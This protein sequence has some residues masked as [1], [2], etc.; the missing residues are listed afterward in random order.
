ML[1][2]SKTKSRNYVQVS[3]YAGNSSVSQT[4]RLDLVEGSGVQKRP[5][6]KTFPQPQKSAPVGGYWKSWSTEDHGNYSSVHTERNG[7]SFF[8]RYEDGPRSGASSL[9]PANSEIPGVLSDADYDALQRL[10]TQMKGE[11]ANL[12]NMIAERKQVSNM[13]S[14]TMKKLALSARDLRRGRIESAIR[15]FGGDPRTARKLRGKDIADQWLELQYGWKPLLSD[16]YSVVNNLHK[17]ERDLLKVFRVSSKKS[18]TSG[19]DSSWA[20][21]GTTNCGIRNT[22][23]VAKYMIRAKPDLLLAEPASLGFTNP[24]VVLWEVTPWSFVVDWFLPIGEYLENL[25]ASHGWIFYDGCKSE[26][27]RCSEQALHGSSSS[28]T[29]AGWT[30]FNSKYWNAG[31]TYT[32]FSRVV[33]A[34]FPAPKLPRFK[35][36]VSLGHAENAFALMAQAFGKPGRQRPRPPDGGNR[37]GKPYNWGW[38]FQP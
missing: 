6:W 7:G 24:F 23:A 21:E 3:N 18:K 30:Y 35:N 19:S 27:V 10:F 15:R 26:L 13:V 16:V 36:P 25:T 11:G 22:R 28:Y 34:G 32:R 2:S 8:Y 29:S 5:G 33:L 4:Q 37:K 12:A 31:V 20:Y 17:R 9:F 38:D 14:N 1:I